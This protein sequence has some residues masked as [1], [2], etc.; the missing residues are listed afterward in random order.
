MPPGMEISIGLAQLRLEPGLRQPS[1]PSN[2]LYASRDPIT[3]EPK[4]WRLL[5]GCGLGGCF[6]WRGPIKPTTIIA[7]RDRE[8]HIYLWIHICIYIYIYVFVQKQCL[9]YATQVREFCIDGICANQ[10]CQQAQIPIM[11][12]CACINLAHA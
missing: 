9:G 12:E 5:R 7:E 11:P 6:W 10:D 1:S 3:W 8:I 2:C 4:S